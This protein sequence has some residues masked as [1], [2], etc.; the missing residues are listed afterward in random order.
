[1]HNVTRGNGYV[2]IAVYR[3][4]RNDSLLVKK[5]YNLLVDIK[6][7]NL[8]DIDLYVKGGIESFGNADIS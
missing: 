5:L 6:L 2:L 7:G 4:F 8:G 3:P 1:M